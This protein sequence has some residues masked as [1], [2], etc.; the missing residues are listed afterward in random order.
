[1]RIYLFLILI[2]MSSVIQARAFVV[3]QEVTISNGNWYPLP[4]A[5]MKAAA[6]DTALSEFTN[7][8][9]FEI[10]RGKR[11][12]S[13]GVLH[14]DLTLLGPAQVVK[15]TT[16]LALQG[17]ATYVSSVSMDIRGLEYQ[18]IYNAFEYV[19]REA[20]K[21]LNV[22]IAMLTE[23]KPIANSVE[24]SPSPKINDLFNR[25]QKLKR[26]EQLHE[27]RVL[28]EQV[29]E[30]GSAAN[31]QWLAMAKDE[32]RYG[33]PIFEA[34]NLMINSAMKDITVQQ[35]D[36]VMV[37]YLYRQI[38]ANNMHKPERVIEMNRRLDQMVLTS[39][40]ISNALKFTAIG[41]ISSLRIVLMEHYM[42]MG[43]WPEKHRLQK[44]VESYSPGIKI[45][46][47][48][49]KGDQIDLVVED[50]R[51]GVEIEVTG[52]VNGLKIQSR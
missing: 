43:D 7:N 33:L 10:L 11:R 20:A 4:E 34:D 27:A 35:K 12:V 13:D 28:F 45:V 38:L 3:N 31:E 40:S 29:I 2:F 24:L 41:R 32:L 8:G 15:L 22:K 26:E 42:D 1:M 16:T 52:A 50:T 37:T 21:R 6:V 17:K 25:A 46:H 51:S 18:G 19:G 44:L 36:M 49:R 47:Y 39:K 9:G 14:L 5:E 23:D 30:E 48:H